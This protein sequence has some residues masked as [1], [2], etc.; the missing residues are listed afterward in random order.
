MRTLLP[1]LLALPLLLAGC[2]NSAEADLDKSEEQLRSWAQK[3]DRATLEKRIAA[4]QELAEE[5]AKKA[6]K[7][8]E[9]QDPK[10]LA[11]NMERAFKIAAVLALYME[12]LEKQKGG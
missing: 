9:R 2:G 7:G 6:P 3:A 5:I 10:E 12:E 1:W 8:D 11:A 4:L